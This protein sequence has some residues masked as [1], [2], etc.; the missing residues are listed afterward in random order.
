[1]PIDATFDSICELPGPPPTIGTDGDRT[2]T[3]LFRVITRSDVNP[4]GPLSACYCPGLPALLSTY[5]DYN[6]TETDPLA[7]LRNYQPDRHPADVRQFIITCN[8][9]TT[10]P[11]PANSGGLQ[12]PAVPSKPG[13]GGGS[14]DDPTKLL[15][16]LRTGVEIVQ[17]P[18]KFDQQSAG[19]IVDADGVVINA[20]NLTRF[21]NTA[22]E[23]FAA[24]VSY[25]YAMRSYSVSFY[26]ADDSSP[27]NL[28]NT[29]NNAT[30]GL[31]SAKTM[32]CKPWTT[33]LEYFG[34]TGFWLYNFEF[35]YDPL[36]L[37]RFTV[38]NAGFRELVD[39]VPFYQGVADGV[40]QLK[41]IKI[42]DQNGVLTRTSVEWPLNRNGQAIRDPGLNG[43]N[44]LYYR[45]NKYPT[46]N[47][48]NLPTYLGAA[49][50]LD[51]TFGFA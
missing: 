34:V 16:R 45:A 50:D 4:I 22:G 39:P 31:A 23:N 28:G 7:L 1:M 46:G 49:W 43:Q 51:N 32:L 13:T 33:S 6:S 24:G 41:D 5:A 2:Y 18:F 26:R 42:A 14:S 36:F 3:R 17:L 8:Y 15:P 21:C 29:V 9:D 20:D 47:F 40:R 25:P 48:A 38:L 10:R 11:Q 12:G 27:V 35:V 19:A 44:L 30:W 37:H